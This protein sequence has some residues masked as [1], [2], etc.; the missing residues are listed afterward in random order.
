[1]FFQD[2]CFIPRG[3]WGIFPPAAEEMSP[4]A[5]KKYPVRKRNTPACP[6][7]RAKKNRSLISEAAIILVTRQGRFRGFQR[8]PMYTYITTISGF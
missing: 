4:S 1:M 3:F 6:K 5:L 7:E 8:T 2:E